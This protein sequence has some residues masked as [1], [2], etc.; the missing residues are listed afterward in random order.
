MVEVIGAR[1]KNWPIKDGSDTTRM[2]R[3]SAGS[4]PVSEISQKLA[5]SGISSRSESVSSRGPNAPL[6]LFAPRDVDEEPEYE[7][8]KAPRAAA[9]GAPAP[10]DY[11]EFFVDQGDIPERAVSPSKSTLR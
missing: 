2:I 4:A 10:R 7:K 1:G 6:N 11:G 8:V 9:S 3:T 5:G